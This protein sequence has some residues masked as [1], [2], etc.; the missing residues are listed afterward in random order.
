MAEMDGG[1]S[2]GELGVMRPEVQSIAR[3]LAVEAAI[4]LPRQ[5][6]GEDSVSLAATRVC[7][8][9]GTIAAPLGAA[10]LERLPLEQA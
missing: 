5:M 6:D 8:T 3:T 1:L 4:D 7:L 2:D 9:E 10:L